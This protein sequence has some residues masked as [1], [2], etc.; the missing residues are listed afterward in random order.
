M[1]SAGAARFFKQSVALSPEHRPHFLARLKVSW[2]R[3]ERSRVLRKS[4]S[5]RTTVGVS[6]NQRLDCEPLS[7]DLCA[8]NGLGFLVH[9]AIINT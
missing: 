2:A 7:G 8:K 3:L 4:R 9:A 1:L 5:K 6:G